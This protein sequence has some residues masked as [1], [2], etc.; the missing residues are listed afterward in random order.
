MDLP[1]SAARGERTPSLH[2]ARS[3]AK[4][5]PWP[6][7]TLGKRAVEKKEILDFS[8]RQG[9]GTTPGTL[10]SMGRLTERRSATDDAMC[11]RDCNEKLNV[12]VP[13]S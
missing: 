13:D 9:A 10:I 1:P 3:A 7:G 2:C 12:R 8:L 4:T 11:T 5:K 6:A